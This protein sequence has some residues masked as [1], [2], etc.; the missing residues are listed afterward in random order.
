[1][2]F[3]I[4]LKKYEGEVDRVDKSNYF[5]ATYTLNGNLRES[6]DILH[7]SILVDTTNVDFDIFTCNYVS[8]ETFNRHYFIKNIKSV[9]NNL[10]QLDLEVDV[11]YSY[12]DAILNQVAYVERQG[13]EGDSYLK[14]ELFPTQITPIISEVTKRTMGTGYPMWANL[15][16]L[17]NI[18]EYD[19]CVLLNVVSQEGTSETQ[20]LEEGSSENA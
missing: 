10:W 17:N 4:A 20:S 8:I 2:A 3:D 19:I 18:E 12:K 1:M 13:S 11:L 15:E 9:R 5:S 16:V 6:T 7:P 14:D